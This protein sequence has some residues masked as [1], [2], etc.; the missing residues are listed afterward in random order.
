MPTQ[1][2]LYRQLAVSNPL[3][4]EDIDSQVIER[5]HIIDTD[6][7]SGKEIDTVLKTIERDP[8]RS[9]KEGI[10]SQ[11][12]GT[13]TKEQ[14]KNIGKFGSQFGL[15]VLTGS[16]IAE[17]LGFRPDIIQGEGYTPSYPKLVEETA[18]LA[19]EG[20]RT[21]ALGKGIETGLVGVGAVGEGMMLGGALTGPLAP[22]IIGAGLTLK[23]ISKAGKLILQSKAGQKVLANFTGSKDTGYHVTDIEI[24]KNITEDKEIQTLE[25][26]KDIPTS[27][28]DD[29]DTE[30]VIGPP[31]FSR[32]EEAV[33]NLKQD[34]GKGKDIFNEIHKKFRR[35]EGEWIGLEKFLKDKES[36]TKEEI[37]EYIRE[38]DIP[39]KTK[40]REGKETIHKKY[41]IGG[42]KNYREITFYPELPPSEGRRVYKPS[43]NYPEDL[44]LIS[45]VRVVERIDANGNPTM[46]IEEA[47]SEHRSDILKNKKL[48]EK[49]T[50]EISKRET[51]ID[52]EEITEKL[53]NLLRERAPLRNTYNAKI[54]KLRDEHKK[55]WRLTH[56]DD[57]Y[58]NI[59]YIF[60][61]EAR[62]GRTIFRKLYQKRDLI[63]VHIL[64][65][66]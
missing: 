37:L 2:Q 55:S 48:M 24:P 44:N 18:Q 35:E 4:Q 33:K 57:P 54:K 40:V 30:V 8:V 7:E 46:H 38:N 45:R 63:Q 29:T 17:A 61:F 42:G 15:D 25:E 32:V 52:D 5:D 50:G 11:A 47:Q 66:I 19:K 22:A 58:D 51:W 60:T 26:I 64:K 27:K 3:I 43:H 31:V 49:R 6:E 21:E 12:T 13:I 65:L 59:D 53:N 14:L 9:F 1:E 20:K 28:T 23:G 56:P 39:I 41:T 34:K 16:A 36:V 62:T 10:G